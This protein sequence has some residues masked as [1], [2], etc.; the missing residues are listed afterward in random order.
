MPLWTSTIARRALETFSRDLV[1]A[2]ELTPGDVLTLSRGNMHTD[3]VAAGIYDK[4]SA[5]NEKV[6][7]IKVYRDRLLPALSRVRSE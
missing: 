6:M 1:A 4:R 7:A 2:Q 5:R 3:T